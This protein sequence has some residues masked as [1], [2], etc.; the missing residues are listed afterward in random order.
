MTALPAHLT[1]ASRDHTVY[2][3]PDCGARYLGVERCETC[4]RFCRPLGAGGRCPCCSKPVA[5]KDLVEGVT[6]MFSG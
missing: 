2:F 6:I 1:S 4:D 5:L 3:C